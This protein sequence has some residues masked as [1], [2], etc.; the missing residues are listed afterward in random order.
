MRVNVL[1]A[2]R[3]CSDV[4][5]SKLDMCSSKFLSL[6]VRESAISFLRAYR[7]YI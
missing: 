2:I 6:S 7:I 5:I 4:P 1:I 3:V